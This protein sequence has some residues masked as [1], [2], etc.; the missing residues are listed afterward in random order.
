MFKKL[1]L[2]TASLI[3]VST[4]ADE[5]QAKFNQYVADLKIEAIEKGFSQKIVDNAFATV[6]F[7]K[8]V[9]KAD[10]NQPEVKETLETYLPKRV[11][12]WKIDRARKLYKENQTELEKI[13]A[14]YGVQARFIVALWG[15]ES[16]FGKIQGSHPVISSV[17]TLAYDGRREAL[18]KRQLWAAL[19][20]LEE[21]H[22]DLDHFKGSW[23]G[24]MGQTQFMPT[25]FNA[26]AVDYDGD[27]KKDI[28]QNKL[29][30]FASIANYLKKSGLE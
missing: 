24:A 29:D 9:I 21:G 14:K 30:A 4:F 22:I 17:V 13:A 6:K 11:P 27:G 12:K 1:A 8:K 18:Y 28:W 7:K 25:S 19:T 5:E 20:I 2:I 26:Y 23:A 3:S 15:L 10:K 16:N